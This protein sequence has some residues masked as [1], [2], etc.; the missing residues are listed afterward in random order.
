MLDSTFG[1]NTLGT[2]S[3]GTP[4]TSIDN[5]LDSYWGFLRVESKRVVHEEAGHVIVEITFTGAANGQFEGEGLSP[6]AEPEYDLSGTVTAVPFSEHP[7]WKALN[8]F[9]RNTLGKLMA[10]QLEM[11]YNTA[12]SEWIVILPRQGGGEIDALPEGE[13]VTSEDGLAFA[14]LIAEGQSTYL[15]PSFVWTENTQG[16]AGLNSSQ[17]NKLGRIST[18]RGDPPEPSGGRNWMLTGATQNQRGDLYRTRL[19]W[20]L[21]ERGG[22]SEFLYDT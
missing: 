20:T 13:Q 3:K 7:K 1:L 4:I 8:E 22:H 21:S 12:E 14:M 19:E 9:E 16:N 10:G 6:D 15:V 17:L 18:P 5:T 11:Y 2:F